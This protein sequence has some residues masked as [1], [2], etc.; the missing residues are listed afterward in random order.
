MKL[1]V[2]QKIIFNPAKAGKGVTSVYKGW[3][4]DKKV[5]LNLPMVIEFVNGCFAG[6]IPSST[7][8]LLAYI[9]IKYFD[10][11]VDDFK[12]EDFL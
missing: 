6:V 2:G 1:V 10:V 5:N 8:H 4:I 3:A 11:I 12:L 7:T 9:D